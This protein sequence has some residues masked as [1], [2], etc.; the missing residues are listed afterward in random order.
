MIKR[1]LLPLVPQH[2]K[3]LRRDIKEISMVVPA[4]REGKKKKV[5]KGKVEMLSCSGLDVLQGTGMCQAA[6]G[7]WC[8][9]G[10]LQL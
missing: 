2:Q 10:P 6:V 3:Q 7:F 4:R 5:A 8:G 1:F 9:L